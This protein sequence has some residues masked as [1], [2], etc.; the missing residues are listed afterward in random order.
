[1]LCPPLPIAFETSS[2][3]KNTS[4]LLVSSLIFIE[5]TFAGLSALVIYN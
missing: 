2:N 1:M 5:D 4:A 3:F